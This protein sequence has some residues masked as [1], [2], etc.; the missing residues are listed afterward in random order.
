MCGV[1]ALNDGPET[2][3]TGAGK[4]LSDDSLLK[5]LSIDCEQAHAARFGAFS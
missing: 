5:K 3:S 1:P 2:T 4:M